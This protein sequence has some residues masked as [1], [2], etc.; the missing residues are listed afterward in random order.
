MKRICLFLALVCAFITSPGCCSADSVVSL[1]SSGQ[2][3]AGT[4][5]DATIPFQLV[6]HLIVVKASVDGSAPDYTFV[7][8]TGSI[9]AV[10]KEAASRLGLRMEGA[11][12]ARGA[13]GAGDKV[14][15]TKLQSLS[16]GGFVAKDISAAVFDPHFQQRAGIRVD[17]FIG[18]NFLRFFRVRIDYR[19]KLLTLS[20]DTT[21]VAPVPGA[22]LVKIGQDWKDA[23]VPQVRVRC[24]DA[25]FIASVDTGLYDPFSIPSA[26]LNRTN[27]D[28]QIDGNGAMGSGNFG[29]M[30]KARMVRLSG[31]D[32]GPLKIGKVVATS[33]S[34][35]S[36]A[37]IG[38]GLLSNFTVTIDYPGRQMLLVPNE[39][40]RRMDNLFSTGL[41]ISRDYA[42]NTFVSGFWKS[43]PAGSVGLAPGEEIT[44]VD[45]R[46]SGSYTLA[47]LQRLLFD[48][49]IPSIKLSIKEP[50]GEK[51]YTLGKK[52]LF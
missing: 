26:F 9:T 20:N 44:R 14:C 15:L 28:G 45:G 51:T 24:G 10:S 38:Y 7:L 48:D 34:G 46:P 43:S 19:N 32:I 5:V 23:F 3:V 6:G 22:T 4:H 11:C 40:G 52:Y 17:G 49:A 30:D 39:G 41:A 37:L 29:N 42:G 13:T 35:Q 16:L 36:D 18:S 25:E 33:Q 12:K 31:L 27:M 1:L 2:P 8:D 47:G 50:L 21:P